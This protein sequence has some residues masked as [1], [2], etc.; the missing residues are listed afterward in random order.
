MNV[1]PGKRALVAGT[2]PFLLI[3]ADQLQRAGVDVAGVAETASRADLL[4]ATPALF[5]RPGLVWQGL[6]L[7]LR[8]RRR[9]VPF[10]WNHVLVE[11]QGADAVRRAVLAPCDGDGRPD[12][13]RLHTVEVDTICAGY[14]FVPRIQLAQLAGCRL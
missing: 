11:A 14:G 10:Y 6:R 2:G 7:H 13:D 5:A 8:L 4:C 3:V 1:L 12:R 9:D